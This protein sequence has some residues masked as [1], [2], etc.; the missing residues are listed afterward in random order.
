[1]TRPVRSTRARALHRGHRGRQGRRAAATAA[2]GVLV[3]V[4]AVP[5]LALASPA[6]STAGTDP[7]E[8][9][10]QSVAVTMAPDGTLTE[11]EAT[12]LATE[13]GADE[14]ESTTRSF[15]PDDVVGDLPVRV[16]TSYRTE[17]GAG[18]DLADLDG[19]TGRIEIDLTVQNLTLRP[20]TLQYDVDGSSRSRSA[21]VGAPLTVVASTALDEVDAAS[22][23]T[24][25]PTDGDDVTNGVLSQDA[26]GTTQVQ[27]AT[28][29]APPQIGASATLRLV[30][31]AD[32]FQAP[33]FDLSVQPGLVVDPSVGALV[34]AAFRPGE[35][36]ELALQS[37]TISL[38]GE[39]NTVLARAGETI[40][41]VRTTLDSSAET[42]GT[43]TVA[44][45]EASAIS[46]SSSMKSLDGSVRSLGQ[47]VSASLESTR[48]SVLEQ[49]LAT[50]TTLD[51]MLG[52]TTVKPRPAATRGQGCNT[53]VA[54]PRKAASVYGTVVQVAGQLGGFSD[55]TAAC[56][57]RLQRSILA[58]A[59]PAEPTEETCRTASVT[60][61]L[62][63]AR[64][65]F[66]DIARD[67]VANG[68][69]A[70]S[71]LE[72]ASVADAVAAAT[73][74]S[75]LV[76]GVSLNTA[77]LLE[78]SPLGRVRLELEDVE[79]AL[80]DVDDSSQELRA[81]VDGV[82]DGAVAAR[83]QVD[84]MT[85][86]N[87]ALAAE[88]CSMVGDGSQPDT[89]SAA[90]V[91]EL[92]AFLVTR[93]CDGSTE[94]NPPGGTAMATRIDDQAAAWDAMV[95]A[96]DTSATGSGVGRALAALDAT[97]VILDAE[98][99]LLRTVVERDSGT[100]DRQL[101]ALDA[102]VA[103]LREARTDLTAR[104]TT[105]RDQQAQAIA[106][107]K[108]AIRNAADDA[109]QD[110]NEVVDPQIRRVSEL[111]EQSREVLGAMFDRS[112]SG[113]DTAAAE[114]AKDGASS[115]SAAKKQ[116]ASE[117]RAAGARISRQVA[118]G[119][120]GIAQGVASST[121]DTEAAAA[122]L[123]QDLNRV[124]LDLG[125]REVNGSGLLGAMTTGAATARSADYQLALATDKTTSYANVRSADVSGLL[126]RQA[127]SDAA[128]R[129]GA[130]LP[131]FGMDLPDG[132]DHR[133]VYTFHI[134]GGS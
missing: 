55:A 87:A 125:D 22:V 107:V 10:L 42:L 18:T 66:G 25:E 26:E 19:H 101:Q 127:Q 94:L 56:K 63:G 28:I 13:S 50:V 110:V 47:D 58:S 78:D 90:K 33:S 104:I 88:L 114:I 52:D 68:D 37:R 86:Q 1:M 24:G 77:A 39:V 64:E 7:A 45:L 95:A 53:S 8:R 36:S 106:D 82:H 83:A 85:T 54:R 108:A 100:V 73:R 131:A 119:L 91:E 96:T 81:V 109:T 130:E 29:L 129:M 30:L 89:L 44:D 20:Q 121:R 134:G 48:S 11:V 49:L 74:L 92:R 34:D 6:L 117:Q 120:A 23:V 76:D 67:L 38:V 123:T 40:S 115:L 118:D 116:Y 32:D 79:A 132:T 61:A 43:K 98:L 122:L 112:A 46:V 69:Q 103:S 35:S 80:A 31:D 15:S 128:L 102:T 126:L 71:A 97:L 14:A 124:L 70:L 60:C 111:S 62:Y 113:L 12:T 51:R 93:S 3:L 5:G 84:A 21:L 41:K 72:P 57:Q 9:V 65:S 75:S 4:S 2:A 16:L 99:T 133:T 59:G 17:D 105:V 27:W